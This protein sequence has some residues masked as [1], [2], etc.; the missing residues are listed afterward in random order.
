MFTTLKVH[1]VDHDPAIRRN[2]MTLARSAGAKLETHRSC[3]DF[4]D[5]YAPDSPRCLAVDVTGIGA[6]E[7]RGLREIHSRHDP[8]AVVALGAN[9]TVA[10]AVAVLKAGA[11]DFIEKP[12][13]IEDLAKAVVDAMEVAKR[14]HADRREKQEFTRRLADL[15]ERQR[16]ILRHVVSG[17]TNKV[18]AYELGISERTVEV[19]RYHLMRRMAVGSAVELARMVGAF[20]DDS[21]C[22]CAADVCNQ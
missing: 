9:A 11:V 3:A 1:I 4:L 2:A 12:C 13:R 21:M 5:A 20:R 10:V 14:R 18:M 19:H 16:E 6:E 8:I 7:L 17:K 15:S 22:S